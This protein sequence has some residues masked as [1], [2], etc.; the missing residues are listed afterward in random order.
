MIAAPPDRSVLRVTPLQVLPDI[1]PTVRRFEALG[2]ER[3]ETGDDGC[4]GLRAGQT[5]LI[6]ASAAF[7]N[8]DYDALLTDRLLGQTVPYIHVES[9]AE[10]SRRLGPGARVLQDV[11]TRGGTRELLVEADGD[12][13]ILAEKLL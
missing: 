1:T 9:V 7:M 11:W 10:A 6:L 12:L 3:V 2:F 5:A 13:L 8:G 4:V